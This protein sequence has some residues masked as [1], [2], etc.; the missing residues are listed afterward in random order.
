MLTTQYEIINGD[1]NT[2]QEEIFN[3]KH[4]LYYKICAKNT[5]PASA[6]GNKGV[7]AEDQKMPYVKG[8]SKNIKKI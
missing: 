7:N 6:D 1:S 3:I 4:T 5:I 2:N 8:W